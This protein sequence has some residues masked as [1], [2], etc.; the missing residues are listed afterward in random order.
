MIEYGIW[1]KKKTHTH[2]CFRLIIPW[3]SI[4]INHYLNTREQAKVMHLFAE[5]VRSRESEIESFAY[6]CALN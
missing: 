2:S 1:F 4:I 6:F 3:N 5:C